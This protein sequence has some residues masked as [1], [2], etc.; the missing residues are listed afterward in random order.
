MRRRTTALVLCLQ[1]RSVS[2][3]RCIS[4][5]NNNSIWVVLSSAFYRIVL[6][7]TQDYCADVNFFN[8]SGFRWT[9]SIYFC[10]PQKIVLIIMYCPA[11]FFATLFACAPKR[12]QKRP[13]SPSRQTGFA[14]RA[15]CL[16]APPL[17]II[18][19]RRA[20]GR[21]RRRCGTSC[22]SADAGRFRGRDGRG[23]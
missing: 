12:P 22:E 14:G 21:R 8:F 3:G 4:Y 10:E 6:K 11:C 15:E 13:R 7:K 9:Y 19:A 17:G 5:K 1:L 23:C 18:R 16:C 2:R 20:R